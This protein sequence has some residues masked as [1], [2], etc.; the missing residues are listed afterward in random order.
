M[1]EFMNG[2]TGE[3]VRWLPLALGA[4]IVGS[5]PFGLLIGFA[6]GVDIREH[7]SRNIGA[8][9]TGRVLGRP[10]GI[11]CFVLDALKG[12][13]PVAT[14]GLVMGA[15]GAAPAELGALRLSLW[16]LVAC[17][18]FIGH[19]APIWLRFRGGKGVATGFGALLAMWPILTFPA[20]LAILAWALVLAACRMMS[21]AS[22]A[23]AL[24]VPL[25]LALMAALSPAGAASGLR[26][27]GPALAVTAA[28]AVL[29]I[30]RHRGNL[31]RIRLGTEPRI[32]R[33]RSAPPA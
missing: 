14:A 17:A 16:L 13:V 1:N 4:Y 9:N 21:L 2:T 25:S 22:I 24:S 32:G 3:V 31:A 5:I 28:L 7:G 8:T 18:S 30:W 26:A 23:G 11:L 27:T 10:F 33:P 20:L 29:V 15:W 6:R 12:A 19:V